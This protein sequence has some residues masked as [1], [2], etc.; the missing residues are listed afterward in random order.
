MVPT[1]L[2][3]HIFPSKFGPFSKTSPNLNIFQ[4]FY[5]R[6]TQVSPL[7]PGRYYRYQFQRM[8]FYTAR[9]SGNCDYFWQSWQSLRCCSPRSLVAEHLFLFHATCIRAL[10][11]N[12]EQKRKHVSNLGI[13]PFTKQRT[14]KYLNRT[15]SA[16]QSIL[17]TRADSCKFANFFQ[18]L[19]IFPHLKGS[20]RERHQM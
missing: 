5:I 17:C 1:S 10:L 19:S 4:S 2:S 14:N 13:E 7:E 11:R 3:L 9:S 20:W 15:R 18:D 16:A 12:R 8:R 6:L